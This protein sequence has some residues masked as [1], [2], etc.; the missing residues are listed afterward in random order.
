MT[1]MKM[2]YSS[3]FFTF[4]LTL[5]ACSA[6]ATP[7]PTT[8]PISKISP[9]MIVQEFLTDFQGAP[10]QLAGYLSPKLQK[11]T[12]VQDY[13]KLLPLSGMIEGFSVQS[14]S[15]SGSEA[16]VNVAIRAG[17]AETSLQFNLIE[18]NQNWYIDSITKAP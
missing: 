18:K 7:T 5:A 8:M 11:S 4:I 3:L 9:E 12:T 15:R 6:L 1:H 13:P 14:A 10:M 2:K 17:G 16:A